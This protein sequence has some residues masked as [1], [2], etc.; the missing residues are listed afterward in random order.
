M[1][2]QND[3]GKGISPAGFGSIESPS[4]LL[5]SIIFVIIIINVSFSIFFFVK[6]VHD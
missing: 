5:L 3:E 1:F 2:G 6:R 4:S